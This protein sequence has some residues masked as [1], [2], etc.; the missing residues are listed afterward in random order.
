MQEPGESKSTFLIVAAVVAILL[1]MAAVVYV[2]LMDTKEDPAAEATFKAL[3]TRQDLDLPMPDDISADFRLD[4]QGNWVA[5]GPVT[6]KELKK[7]LG[8]QP[9]IQSL[10]IVGGEISPEGLELLKDR[11]VKGLRFEYMELTPAHAD[12]IS[13]LPDLEFLNLRDKSINDEFIDHL[14]CN[15]LKLQ[16][17]HLF[18]AKITNRSIE[19]IVTRFPNLTDFG[20]ARNPNFDDAGLALLKG[21]KK[22]DTLE[23]NSTSVDK[24]SVLAFVKSNPKIK[25]LYIADLQID[26]AYVAKLPKTLVELDLSHNPITDGSIDS[27]VQMS[28]LRTFR[29][30]G[31]TMV[32]VEGLGRLKKRLPL[33]FV[34][35]NKDNLNPLGD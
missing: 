28:K 21:L 25:H 29:L 5:N 16:S 8:K 34:L 3:N 23:V 24:E 1:I 10:H 27:I 7:L 18:M 31:K 30:S 32:T 13:T 26:D 35:A 17:L 9:V 33:C 6:D 11:G 19:T 14:K 2:L 4:N 22:L 20:N 15:P 12:A